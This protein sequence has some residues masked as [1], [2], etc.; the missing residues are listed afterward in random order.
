MKTDNNKKTI[1]NIRTA[2]ILIVIFAVIFACAIAGLSTSYAAVAVKNATGIVN[3]KS[4]VNLRASSSTSS[5]SVCKLKN[6]TKLTIT[7]VV[8]KT[9]DSTANKNKWY[10]VTVN[11]KSGYVRADLVSNLKFN[12]VNAVTTED[13]NYR[14]GAGT[15]MKLQGC[16]P[17]GTNVKVLLKATPV[18]ATN[19][20]NSTWYMIKVDS[21]KY[22]AC[23]T[24][25]KLVDGSK[26]EPANPDDP[27]GDVN[28]GEGNRF[29][30]MTNEEFEAYLVEQGFPESYR[31][32]L[33]TLHEKHPNWIFKANITGLEW[34][35]VLTKENKNGVSL[36]SSSMPVSYRA[37]DSNSYKNGSAKVYKEANTD[38]KIATVKNG[39]TF[40][41]LDE[42]WKGTARWV[43]IKMSDGTKGYI[44]SS[45]TSLKHPKKYAATVN[46]DDVNLRKGAGTDN[47]VVCTTKKGDAITIV[48]KATDKNDNVWYK[49]KLD[50]GYAYII[51]D[52]VDFESETA[53][54]DL[55]K[56]T[57]TA[58]IPKGE[59]IPKDGSS[60]FNAKKSVV[61]YYLDPRNFLNVDRIYMFENLSYDEDSQTKAVVSKV[62]SGSKLPENGF[63]AE[64]FVNAGKTYN[65]SPVFLASRAR[66]ETGGGSSCIN[67]SKYD[68]KI[69]YNP[70]N[71]G[72]YSSS[73]PQQLALKRAYEEGWFT[74]QKAVDGSAEI[75][76][77][78]YINSKYKQNT[79]Y[80]QRFNTATGDLS[81]VATHQYMTNIMA[82][83]SESLMVKNSY[84]AC[85]ID[86]D[87]LTFI[88]PVYKSMPDSTSLPK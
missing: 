55:E 10:K 9:K 31:G 54:A 34:A 14:S 26:T 32:K 52:Y 58:G 50:S 21:K 79:I 56:S 65:I 86:D 87:A 5:K 18:A 38:N 80:F 46:D 37:T 81:Y 11:G 41:I 70:F 3:S 61:A 23:S 13:V 64:V 78:S 63:T 33:M 16:L 7:K 67:G 48:L 66:Q 68:G 15:Q 76:A 6:N 44:K 19:G 29:S 17:A 88:I 28:P 2:N 40:T 20:G 75:L 53:A 57:A 59:Y 30:K 42:K 43:H 49:V 36:I 84:V 69:V 22:Y 72:A 51:S 62:L 25:F 39:D 1:I 71:I 77:E 60:W 73:N 8:F 45:L 47:G 85:G 35:D 4:T 24:Y 12:A 27:S 82:P 74:Q 83:Y